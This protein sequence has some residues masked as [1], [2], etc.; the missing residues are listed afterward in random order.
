MRPNRYPSTHWPWGAYVLVQTLNFH[1][2]QLRPIALLSFLSFLSRS[3]SGSAVS[4]PCHKV[5]SFIVTIALGSCASFV[6]Q[7]CYVCCVLFI[8]LEPVNLSEVLA[9]LL[10]VMFPWSVTSRL[11]SHGKTAFTTSLDASSLSWIFK[12]AAGAVGISQRLKPLLQ[13]LKRSP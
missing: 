8:V 10:P 12:N 13:M 9:Y 11:G 6:I 1:G 4:L 5:A 2:S 7:R 3:V